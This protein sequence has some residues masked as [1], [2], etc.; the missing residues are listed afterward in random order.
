MGRFTLKMKE[1]LEV[2]RDVWVKP[3]YGHFVVS[4][5]PNE[6]G[7]LVAGGT[8]ITSLACF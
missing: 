3:P 7:V 5:A 8:G 2:G 4:S 1:E 6:E